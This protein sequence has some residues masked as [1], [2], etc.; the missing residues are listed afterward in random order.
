MMMMMERSW[1]AFKATPWPSQDTNHI[2]TLSD[3]IPGR[4]KTQEPTLNSF[5]GHSKNELVGKL[6][7]AK[8]VWLTTSKLPKLGV[9]QC[10]WITSYQTG[11]T[12]VVLNPT[13][14]TST[15]TNRI[16]HYYYLNELLTLIANFI[17]ATDEQTKKLF[18]AHLC[19]RRPGR[20]PP[21]QRQKS[22]H[23]RRS[24]RSEVDCSPSWC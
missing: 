4:I 10:C 17:L 6:E 3:D 14:S 16:C 21:K 2:K 24:Q 19:Q 5:K 20:S 11:H 18:I 9:S 8:L 23:R 13:D 15:F 12:A 22:P 7:A 1:G